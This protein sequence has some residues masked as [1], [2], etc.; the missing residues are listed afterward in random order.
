VS[1]VEIIFEETGATPVVHKLLG[2]SSRA[3]HME[4]GLASVASMMREAEQRRF[5]AEGYG[6][7]EQLAPAT[8]ARKAAEGLDYR[9]LRATGA[10]YD[11]LT[12]EGGDNIEVVTDDTLI[13]GSSDPK[14]AFHQRGNEHLPQR[15]PLEMREEDRI[16]FTRELQRY[17]VDGDV[18]LMGGLV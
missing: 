17:L 7:W 14:G 11:S 3:E 9:I 6:E 16:E 15:K 4:P 1:N 2:F 18:A 12:Q 5:D 13:F 10:L 8:V